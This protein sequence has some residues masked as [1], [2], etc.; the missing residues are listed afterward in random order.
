MNGSYRNISLILL[1]LSLIIPYSFAD[2]GAD[3]IFVD[4]NVGTDSSSPVFIPFTT[5]AGGYLEFTATIRNGG[6]ESSPQYYIS[7]YLIGDEIQTFPGIVIGEVGGMHL[8]AGEEITQTNL[9]SVPMNTQSGK[10]QILGII[11]PVLESSDFDT[12]NNRITTK[13]YVRL[14]DEKEDVKTTPVTGPIVIK[15]AGVYEIKDD[16]TCGKMYAIEIQSSGVTIDGGGHTITGVNNRA[17]CGVYVNGKNPL[18]DITIKNLNLKR[19]GDGIWL[20]EVRDSMVSGCS[21]SQN[22]DAGIRLDKSLNNIIL[23]NIIIENKQ[24]VGLFQSQSNDIYNNYLAN[25]YNVII[26]EKQNNFWNTTKQSGQ[27]VTGGTIIGGNVWVNPDGTGFSKTVPDLDSDG[28]GD[29]PYAIDADNIDYLPLKIKSELQSVQSLPLE[30]YEPEVNQSSDVSVPPAVD[31][32]APAEGSGL[33]VSDIRAVSVQVDDKSV[34]GSTLS[35]TGELENS[36]TKDTDVCTIYFYLSKDRYS[37]ENDYFAGVETI[38]SLSPEE[39]VTVPHTMDI[40]SDIENGLYYIIMVADASQILSESDETNNKAVTAGQIKIQ[41]NGLEDYILKQGIYGPKDSVTQNMIPVIIEEIPVLPEEE[42]QKSISE[43]ENRTIEIT[44]IQDDIIESVTYS[45]EDPVNYEEKI[46]PDYELETDTTADIPLVQEQYQKETVRSPLPESDTIAADIVATEIRAVTTGIIGD[47]IVL[48]GY[49]QNLGNQASDSYHV[50]YF[51][52]EDT[53][54]DGNDSR[55]GSSISRPINPGCQSSISY[56]GFIPKNVISG[57]YYVAMQ[58]DSGQNIRE[59]DEKNNVCWTDAPIFFSEKEKTGPS[60]IDPVYQE[61]YET[62]NESVSVGVREKLFTNDVPA[63]SIGGIPL[64]IV[65]KAMQ[66]S[67]QAAPMN[68]HSGDRITMNGWITNAE[69]AHQTVWITY[70]LSTD[71]IM[72]SEDIV[73]GSAHHTFMLPGETAPNTIL[74]FIPSDIKTGYYYI[75]GVVTTENVNGSKK[76]YAVAA[77]EKII[78]F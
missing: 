4:L 50:A 47:S 27:S 78:I 55:I 32:G 61:L 53:K 65:N 5:Y 22:D 8:M 31:S 48:E 3:L 74:A 30:Q 70:Y 39:M 25:Q 45:K 37:D 17:S 67:I 11:N 58:A 1:I 29:I 18:Q 33:L 10:Y 60:I 20:Y 59:G 34:F 15:E 56:A 64:N 26:P 54:L 24:G 63:A 42:T 76:D 49:V 72:S 41:Q 43:N 7:Y 66:V 68:V 6:E 62:R 2:I 28:I 9:L 23:N 36:G 46:I 73:L 71:T 38:P 77:T 21:I 35:L 57:M 51:L 16:F 69:L 40:P 44:Q 52:S 75:I 14:G 12:D 19:F 13:E